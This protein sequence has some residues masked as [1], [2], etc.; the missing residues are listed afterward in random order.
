MLKLLKLYKRG[1]MKNL[2][3]GFIIFATS[4]V[5]I[6]SIPSWLKGAT[7]TEAINTLIEMM[8]EEDV[9]YKITNIQTTETTIASGQDAVEVK[10]EFNDSLGCS[11]REVISVCSALDDDT[12]MICRSWGSDCK[13]QFTLKD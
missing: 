4:S 5:A 8:K 7:R 1:F 2:I 12:A 9:F 3:F 10:I 6:A 13:H 11:N